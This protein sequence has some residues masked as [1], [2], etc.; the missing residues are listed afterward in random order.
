[1]ID[2]DRPAAAPVTSRRRRRVLRP[3]VLA[4]LAA[5]M[6][7]L[8]GAAPVRAGLAPVLRL[9]A[10]VV[11][12][13]LAA[14]S[15]FVAHP[16]G[17]RRYDL[18]GGK[19][20]WTRDLDQNVQDVQIASDAGVVLAMS[21]HEPALTAL[22]AT[23]GEVLWRGGSPID[24]LV[25][26]RGGVLTRTWAAG[27]RSRLQLTDARTGRPVWSRQLDPTAVVGPEELLTTGAPRI[28]VA[29]PAGSVT[30]L[31]FADGAVLARG[32]LAPDVA[33]EVP[34]DEMTNVLTVS[35]L[36]E[37]IYLSRNLYGL[38]T[39]TAH[40]TTSLAELWQAVD[41]PAGA[42]T[43]CGPVLCMSDGLGITALDPDDGAVRWTL[44]VWQHAFRLDRRHLVAL[45]EP[46]AAQ[47]V[48]LDAA[49]GRELRALG[50]SGPVG[51]LLV[52]TEGN[53]ALVSTAGREPGSLRT[54]G[55][56]ADVVWNR[57][58]SR[59]GYLACLTTNGDTAVWRVR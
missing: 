56:L 38:R 41:Q 49:T 22:D 5:T 7:A 14:G 57:C 47:A 26:A 30:V 9:P 6:L 52:R 34:P 19:L 31:R 18:A 35:M 4:L 40:A 36:G 55:V 23:T 51:D 15:L 21:S 16:T 13:R 20:R 25:T 24:T 12:V 2:L 11:T 59:D 1:M 39:L 45:G 3:A 44:P 48:L 42:V 8:G 33:R 50:R 17:V 28:V 46:D 29:T 32:D 10:P 58:E 27:D 43:D 54:L 37:R 53:L